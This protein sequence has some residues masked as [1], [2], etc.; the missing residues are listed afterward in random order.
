MAFDLAPQEMPAIFILD[1]S[2]DPQHVQKKLD[3]RWLFRLQ[4]ILTRSPDSEVHKF[5]RAVGKAIWA[6]SATEQTEQKFRIHPQVYWIKL[7]SISSDLNMLE[8]NRVAEMEIIVHHR[9]RLFDL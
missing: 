8:A 9:R 1:D 4:L 7:G 3:M 2:D 6:D 5:V